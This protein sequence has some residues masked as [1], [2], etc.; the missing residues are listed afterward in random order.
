MYLRRIVALIA[1]LLIGPIGVLFAMGALGSL[2]TV[3]KAVW[4][5]V[6]ERPDFR[7]ETG[8]V[9]ILRTATPEWF[10]DNVTFYTFVFVVLALIAVAIIWPLT[11]CLG[12]CFRK[13]GD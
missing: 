6:L 2:L 11:R 12:R 4:T 9:R 3:L 10:W 5:G 13:P 1:M 8:D 7:E